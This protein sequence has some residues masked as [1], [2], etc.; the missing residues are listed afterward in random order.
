MRGRTS[1]WDN[2]AELRES[3]LPRLLGLQP[4]TALRGPSSANQISA[5]SGGQQSAG[6]SDG[7]K[8]DSGQ[9]WGLRRL[10]GHVHALWQAI[11][12]QGLLHPLAWGTFPR[13]QGA[14]L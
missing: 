9:G 10:G 7:I 14:S 13:L 1:L 11:N 6:S 5:G 8:S 12:S 4:V 3:G 2:V